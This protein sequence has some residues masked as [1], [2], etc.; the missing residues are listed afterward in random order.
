[1]ALPVLLFAICF[2]GSQH[3]KGYK[4]SR[5]HGTCLASK[6]RFLAF[7]MSLASRNVPIDHGQCRTTFRAR[8]GHEGRRVYCQQTRSHFTVTRLAFLGQRLLVLQHVDLCRTSVLFCLGVHLL[9]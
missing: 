8:F 7:R 9:V 2:A 3:R 1:M 5:G 6:M 4:H